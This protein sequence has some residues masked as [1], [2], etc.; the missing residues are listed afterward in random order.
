MIGLSSPDYDVNGTAIVPARF[1]NAYQ[2]ERR[3]TV[4]ATLDGGV[5]VYDGGYTIADH[6]MTAVTKMTSPD[7]VATLQYMISMY[8][9]LIVT[10][11]SGCYRAVVSFDV[12]NNSITLT[13][14]IVARLDS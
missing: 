10:C 2:A 13:A 14:R 9:Q 8:G 11:E 7:L 3:G 6:T 4:T 12:N 5:S 1:R